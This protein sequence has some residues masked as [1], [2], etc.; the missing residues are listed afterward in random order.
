[1]LKR[2]RSTSPSANKRRVP[3]SYSPA[4]YSHFPPHLNRA[5]SSS[6]SGASSPH[7]WVTRTNELHLATPT[8]PPG[9]PD[10]HDGDYYGEDVGMMSQ[11]FEPMEADDQE[12]HRPP[13]AL[14]YYHQQNHHSHQQHHS[15]PSSPGFR[16]SPFASHH[17]TPPPPAPPSSPV[18]PHRIPSL[19]ANIAGSPHS[20]SISLSRSSSSTDASMSEDQVVVDPREVRLPTSPQRRPRSHPG[21]AFSMG[22]RADCDKCVA[23]VPGHYTHLV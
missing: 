4:I 21:Q 6:S 11:E 15:L 10:M 3:S 1:M 5:L 16:G 18:P 23:R 20:E 8:P 7:D 22:F 12:A 19:Y 9:S 2:S 17:S 13:D 14:A